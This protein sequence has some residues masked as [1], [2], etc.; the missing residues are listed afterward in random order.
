LEKRSKSSRRS[1]I[2]RIGQAAAPIWRKPKRETLPEIDPNEWDY[3][4]CPHN[5]LVYCYLYTL[6]GLLQ[7][8][9]FFFRTIKYW[10]G[11]AGDF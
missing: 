10:S 1:K 2:R 8:A 5:E 3:S 11:F 7:L 6:T 9:A 4:Q